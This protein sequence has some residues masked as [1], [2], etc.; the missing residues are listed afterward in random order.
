MNFRGF[1]LLC[2]KV[3]GAY[4]MNI[5]IC[6]DLQVERD[7]LIKTIKNFKSNALVFEYE[8]GNEIIA[9]HK[10]N[11]YDLVFLDILMPIMNG[12][13][14]AEAIREYD[15]ETHIVFLTTSEEFAVRSYRVFAFDYLLKPIR[16]NEIQDCLR[17]FTSLKMETGSINVKFMGVD[18]K[19]LISNILYLESNLHKIVFYLTGNR[20]IKLT[21]K[22]SDYERL[23]ENFNFCRCHKSYIVNVEHIS[24]ISGVEY[25]MTNGDKIKIS[26]QYSYNAKKVYFN[27][28]F[29]TKVKINE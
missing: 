6:D 1:W 8:N 22:L 10:R 28:V 9:D 14:V 27:Y 24:S 20:E 16:E 13:D 5:A 4:Y 12:M 29:A 19:I 17:R 21:A 11:R 15:K 2:I 26:R 25:T 18:T 7:I 23:I 3:Q